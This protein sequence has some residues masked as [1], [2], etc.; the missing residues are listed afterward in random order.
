MHWARDERRVPVA[1]TL[2]PLCDPAGSVVALASIALDIPL[3]AG[4]ERMLRELE[5]RLHVVFWMNDLY[6]HRFLYVSPSYDSIWGRSHQRLAQNPF[7]WL[8]AVFP[9][10]RAR[11]A[12]VYMGLRN[13][14]PAELE[15]RVVRPDGALRALHASATPF[16]DASGKL[17]LCA[18]IARDVTDEVEVRDALEHTLHAAER[19]EDRERKALASDL[20]DSVGQLLPLARMRLDALLDD[21]KLLDAAHQLGELRSLLTQAEQQIRTLTFRLS[22][23]PINGAGLAAAL[24]R[25]AEH[26][27]RIWIT[28]A[29]TAAL[30]VVL[31]VSDWGYADVYRSEARR[32]R[33]E[34]GPHARI[35]YAG[36]WGWQ[37]YAQRE[38][39]LQYRNRPQR[40]AHRRLLRRADWH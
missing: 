36:H 25:L 39:M 17:T 6:T 3:L 14:E 13:G 12:A 30:A 34:L 1:L 26:R 4:C 28:V 10:D 31:A 7:D 37:W 22:P 27:N 8:D 9:P 33:R 23:S 15:C 24:L 16:A 29:V 38:D 5:S 2:S 40:P 35:W 11:A 32:L 20:H 19:A 18:G 21:P